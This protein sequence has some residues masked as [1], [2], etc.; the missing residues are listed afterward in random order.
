MRRERGHGLPPHEHRA[1][2]EGGVRV[3]P[4]M[5]LHAL[6][7]E[8]G[9]DPR[10]VFADTGFHPTQLED[11]DAEVPF[12]AGSR[13]L[14]HA[15]AT[16]GC[17]QLGLLLGERAEVSALGVTGFML[18]CAPDVE[19]ALDD[20]VHY[21]DLHDRGATVMLSVEGGQARVGYSAHLSGVQALAQIYDLA[22]TVI[23][24][25]MRKLCGGSWN[26]TEVL[27]SRRAPQ[28][29]APYRRFFRAPLRFD[30]PQSSLC[31][32]T[33]CLSEPVRSAD[34]LL[35]RH[36]EQVA[37]RLHANR[38]SSLT[39]EAQGL[40]RRT[41]ADGKCRVDVIASQLGMHERTLHRHL[42][43]E[44]T[45][46]RRELDG[47]RYETARRLLTDT[48][49]PLSQ[50]AA[51]LDYA[52]ATAF[53]RAFKRWSG[54]P[55]SEWRRDHRTQRAPEPSSQVQERWSAQECEARPRRNRA[56]ANEAAG[57]G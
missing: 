46:F 36:L 29:V 56:A 37:T 41:L 21:L 6:V 52:D 49:V 22:I 26:P 23:C 47:I 39:S 27:L 9:A 48:S 51:A 3:G 11:P 30:T 53:I 4:L 43:L 28:E 55:P 57:P 42:Q 45:T 1:P 14:A 15:V 12:V 32:P 50:I 31:F 35:H 16:T 7:A 40:M 24:K 10:R 13:L 19:T 17:E 18:Q 44:G 2:T 20:L 8:L 34:P 33:H 38:H 54:Q 25:I 5:N